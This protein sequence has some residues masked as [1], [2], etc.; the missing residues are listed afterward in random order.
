MTLTYGED[1]LKV[2]EEGS[3]SGSLK[4]LKRE[5]YLFFLLIA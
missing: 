4:F 5:E 2:G 1:I 3:W